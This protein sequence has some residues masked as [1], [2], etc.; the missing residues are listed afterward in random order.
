MGRFVG[1]E[2][3]QAKLPIAHNLICICFH[4]CLEPF[5]QY[6]ILLPLGLDLAIRMWFI[7]TRNLRDYCAHK[8]LC[9]SYVHS[10][11][12]LKSRGY[13]RKAIAVNGLLKEQNIC[14]SL[15]TI[16]ETK[17]TCTSTGLQA[18]YCVHA[19]TCYR[20]MYPICI[21]LFSAFV[22]L[23]VWEKTCSQ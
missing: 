8:Y 19:V 2:M 12:K 20:D 22:S 14:S 3:Y 16:E 4:H 6:L 21:I 11:V 13:D 15:R 23:K 1:N 7:G 10:C 5:I 9:D 17:M 18:I